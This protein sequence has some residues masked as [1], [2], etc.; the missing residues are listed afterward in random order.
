ML[1]AVPKMICKWWVFHIYF[2][3]F[4]QQG[5][6]I[7][8]GETKAI[9]RW[10]AAVFSGRLLDAYRS[11]LAKG[12]SWAAQAFWQTP[13]QKTDHMPLKLVE[14]SW[15]SC[16]AGFFKYISLAFNLFHPCPN[17]ARKT[18]SKA[19][20][21]LRSVMKCWGF[22]E[23]TWRE[24]KQAMKAV[25]VPA[26]YRNSPCT[27]TSHWQQVNDKATQPETSNS[28]IKWSPQQHQQQRKTLNGIWPYNSVKN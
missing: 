5:T 10:C 24:Q 21:V 26:Q 28:R 13:S 19:W 2:C 1:S 25:R 23:A 9:P 22:L 16:F 20:G 14:S 11:G 12:G 6:T 3:G 15:F 18:Y 7:S 27:L 8:L 17:K 4:N